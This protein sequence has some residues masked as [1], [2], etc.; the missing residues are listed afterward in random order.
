[1]G[2]AYLQQEPEADPLPPVDGETLGDDVFGADMDT[3]L[4]MLG[5]GIPDPEDMDGTAV[6]SSSTAA[7]GHGE[8]A[9]ASS[10]CA[11][12][13]MPTD[14]AASAASASAAVSSADSHQEVAK[15][16][17]GPSEM[18]YVYHQGRLLGR[19]QTFRSNLSVTCY[20][21]GCKILDSLH[22]HASPNDDALNWLAR[23]VQLGGGHGEQVSVS[24]RK[25]LRIQHEQLKSAV[26]SAPPED[27]VA[28]GIS[29]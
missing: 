9:S 26:R 18:G 1:M 29:S 21:H 19:V 2:E 10:T 17:V 25:E 12:E 3:L 28:R 27:H 22:Q 6:A 5:C 13:A 20:W 24:R 4:E 23:G 14:T 16:L 8:S 7:T 11:A 15:N